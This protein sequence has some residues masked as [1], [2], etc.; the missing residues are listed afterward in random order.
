MTDTADHIV[1][2]ARAASEFETRPAD[3]AA[4]LLDAAAMLTVETNM[5]AD[6]AIQRFLNSHQ[7]FAATFGIAKGRGTHAVR[8]N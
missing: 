7:T 4:L 5:P 1:A 2:L 6:E 8:Q 3:A